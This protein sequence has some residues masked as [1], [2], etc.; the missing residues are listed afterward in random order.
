MYYVQKSPFMFEYCNIVQR[1]CE[2]CLCW[3]G[4]NKFPFQHV[5]TSRLQRL[6]HTEKIKL[7]RHTSSYLGCLQEPYLLSCNLSYFVP[8]KHQEF[9]VIW[10]TSSQPQQWLSV[11]KLFHHDYQG[12]KC[13]FLWMLSFHTRLYNFFFFGFMQF[14]N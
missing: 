7:I 14:S 13:I 5:K 2:Q 8:E 6:Q 11:L 12:F 1:A 9:N 3:W 10:E 4:L